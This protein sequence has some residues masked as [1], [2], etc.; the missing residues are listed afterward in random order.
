MA[1]DVIRLADSLQ[2][3]KFTILGHSMGA[4]I[5]MTTACKYPDRIDGVCSVDAAPYDYNSNK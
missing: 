1:D 5:A 2:I 3:D 4:K